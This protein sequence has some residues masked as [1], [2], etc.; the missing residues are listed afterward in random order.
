MI[1]AAVEPAL[2]IHRLVLNSQPGKDIHHLSRLVKGGHGGESHVLLAQEIF[3]HLHAGEHIVIELD[4]PVFLF[5]LEDTLVNQALT[6]VGRDAHIATVVFVQEGVA[7]HQIVVI[8]LGLHNG[9]AGFIAGGA[10][11]FQGLAA[12]DNEGGVDIIVVVDV[13]GDPCG[14]GGQRSAVLNGCQDGGVF[15][16]QPKQAHGNIV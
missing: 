10:E 15:L 5:F 16:A 3:R 11:H 14:D 2:Q 13:A 12:P 1:V 4:V 7:H 6:H 8:G 9:E